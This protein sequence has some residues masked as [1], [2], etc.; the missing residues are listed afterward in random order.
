MVKPIRLVLDWDG[1][2]T[3]KDTMSVIGSIPSQR[4]KRT[5][6]E[7]APSES[8]WSAISKAY[9]DD[10]TSHQNNYRP[11]KADRTTIAQEKDWLRSLKAVEK[12]SAAR[13]SKSGF[14]RGVTGDDVVAT[15]RQAISRGD[16][17]LRPG[18]L[19]LLR[20]LSTPEGIL[21]IVSVN[22]SASFIRETLRASTDDPALLE[23]IANISIT[24]NEIQRLDSPEGSDGS[25]SNGS[26]AVQTSADK[27]ARLF[28]PGDPISA[29]SSAFAYVGDS[30]T[31]FDCLLALGAGIC[32]RD[33]PMGSGQQG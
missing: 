16:V 5:G 25:L 17:Q 8:E 10:Y 7:A 14:F 4:D 23:G 18:C 28:P 31:D 32:I 3:R 26:E 1:T 20:D 12:A 33:E 6:S 27:L 30:A 24:A 9:M 29:A 2:M 11:T 21:D 22:W 19:E 15:A 13:V